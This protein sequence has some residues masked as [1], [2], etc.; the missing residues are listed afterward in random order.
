MVENAALAATRQDSP[1]LIA[2]NHRTVC[3]LMNST[4]SVNVDVTQLYKFNAIRAI[5]NSRKVE[6][7][8]KLFP[9]QAL[10]PQ[11]AIRSWSVDLPHED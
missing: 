6:I 5:E 11:A 8:V 7:K 4:V 9:V 2:S 1:A 10:V 3:F